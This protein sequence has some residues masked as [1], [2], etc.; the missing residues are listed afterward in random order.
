L[1]TNGGSNWEAT[2]STLDIGRLHRAVLFILPLALLALWTALGLP[3]ATAV[4]NTFV[5]VADTYVE[6]S[7]PSTNFGTS[8]QIVADNS[9]VRRLF[10]RFN[11]TNLSQPVSNAKLRIH[12]RNISNGGS[13]SGGTLKSM[14]SK[15]WFETVMTWNSQP[16]I[17]GATLGSLGA[18]ANNTWYEINVTPAVTGNGTFSFGMTSTNNDG[19]YYDSRETGGNAPQL[20]VTTGTAVTTTTTPPTTTTQPASDPVLVGAADIAGCGSSG[21]EATANLLDGIPGTVFTAGDNVYS[22]GTASE[23]NSCYAPSWGRHKARTRPSAG[24]H[25]YNT[26]GATGYYGYFGAAAGEPA[27]GY[28]SYNLGNWH[29]VAINSNCSPIGGCGAGSAQEQWLRQD[30]AASAKP[31]TL[32]YW[33]YPLFTSGSNHSNATAMRPIFQAL[34]D[35]NAEVVVSGHNHNYE[36]FAPQN[37]T[38]GLDNAR[39]IREFVAGMGGISH[40]SFGTIQPNSQA[41]NADTFGVLKLTLHANSYDW[42]FVPQAGKTFSDSGTTAC[43]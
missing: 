40:Y 6:S 34:Y 37:P 28:Y 7:A 30:L 32:A 19:A 13:P 25:D 42:Q 5:P 11:V 24:N 4:T 9:P 17:D 23:F 1:K 8:G 21:D 29:V 35:F 20:V 10:L 26:A 36:R 12:V 15:S 14:T 2:M 38:G 27:K 22:N 3:A 39:G 31:C 41:R 33:H 18:I 43:H 16:P